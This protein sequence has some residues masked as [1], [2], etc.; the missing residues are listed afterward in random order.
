MHSQ[1]LNERQETERVMSE[2]MTKYSSDRNTLQERAA[3][4]QRTLQSTESNKR[5]LEK[6]LARFEK[7]RA[8][9]KKTLE[10]VERQRAATEEAM[11][12]VALE[13]GEMEVALRRLDEENKDLHRQLNNL[14]VHM[15][16]QES[17]HSSKL[18]EITNATRSE[19]GTITQSVII[20]DPLLY[21]TLRCC[22]LFATSPMSLCFFF[23]R[24]GGG[25]AHARDPEASREDHR[26]SRAHP[27]AAH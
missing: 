23:A 3:A 20:A 5:D 17:E 6:T 19:T 15:Q 21:F 12:R 11:S 7:E 14:Q 16:K 18:L 22:L 25:R 9:L 27:Q 4:V 10:R 1:L 24:R 13:R 26:V 2:Q 8:V